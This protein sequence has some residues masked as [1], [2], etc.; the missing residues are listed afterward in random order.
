MNQQCWQVERG[1]PVVLK[2][3]PS[4]PTPVPYFMR[5]TCKCPTQNYTYSDGCDTTGAAASL[6][7]CIEGYLS[8]GSEI[9]FHDLR[10]VQFGIV[11]TTDP[12]DG[13]VD[14]QGH[15]KRSMFCK[16]DAAEDVEFGGGNSS[17]SADLRNNVFFDVE[18]VDDVQFEEGTTLE[19]NIFFDLTANDDFKFQKSDDGDFPTTIINNYFREVVVADKCSIESGFSVLGLLDIENNSCNNF[20]ENGDNFCTT[21]AHISGGFTCL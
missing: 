9:N 16:I 2:P 19:N 8:L 15:I 10:D 6:S 13:D 5:T 4:P 14:F 7:N 1:G 12:T 11:K 21:N 18:M 20:V 17:C 3:S